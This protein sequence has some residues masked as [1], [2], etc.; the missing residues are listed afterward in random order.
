MARLYALEIVR[1]RSVEIKNSLRTGPFE[2][3]GI[4]Q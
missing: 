4:L 2:A 1:A 3:T